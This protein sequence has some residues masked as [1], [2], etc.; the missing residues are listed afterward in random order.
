MEI[1][2]LKKIKVGTENARPREGGVLL[3]VPVHGLC[4]PQL[5]LPGLPHLHRLHARQE[6]AAVWPPGGPRHVHHHIH[7]G[8]RP[9]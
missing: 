7:A 8:D 3:P 4:R 2:R 6:G 1:L 5:G 9:V